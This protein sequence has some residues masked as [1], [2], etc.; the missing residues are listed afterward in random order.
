[1]MSSILCMDGGR[2]SHA[3]VPSMRCPAAL[4]QA[5]LLGWSTKCSC[6][7]L[8]TVCIPDETNDTPIM[9]VYVLP[10]TSI[11]Q[12]TRM[13]AG[14]VAPGHTLAEM[15]D[16]DRIQQNCTRISSI[17]KTQILKFLSVADRAAARARG[18]NVGLRLKAVVLTCTRQLAE[19]ALAWIND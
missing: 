18:L 9:F 4:A 7:L 6:A 8:V 16:R 3:V 5:R 1:M 11:A 13:D 19:N 10:H 12:W 15:R 17:R 2:Q 14:I